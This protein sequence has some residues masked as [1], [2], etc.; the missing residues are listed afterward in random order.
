M[1]RRPA[2][3]VLALAAALALVLVGAAVAAPAAAAVRAHAAGPTGPGEPAVA[4]QEEPGT[5]AGE[6]DGR[7]ETTPQPVPG[8]DI[9]PK[10][11]SGHPPREAGDRGGA[12]QILV[13]VLI[14]AGVGGIA[15]A[16]VRES[17]RKRRAAG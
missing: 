4:G 2:H 17:R 12:L 13:F 9:I 11:N 16:V 3:P 10:P 15:A 8:A 14:V 5:P 6:G 7:T 1:R